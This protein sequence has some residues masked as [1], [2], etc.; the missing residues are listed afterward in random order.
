MLRGEIDSEEG[1]QRCEGKNDQPRAVGA[2]RSSV[3]VY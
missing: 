3:V 2:L 1:V